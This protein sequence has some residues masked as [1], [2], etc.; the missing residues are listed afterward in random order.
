MHKPLFF[1]RRASDRKEA[2]LP[3]MCT[4]QA[5]FLLIL[6]GELLALALTLAVSPSLQ[7]NWTRLGT[8]SFLIQ[9]VVLLS[10]ALLCPLRFWLMNIPAWVAGL[11]C[12]FLVMVV[13]LICSVLGLAAM[14]IWRWPDWPVVANNLLIAAIFGGVVLRYL[15]VQQQWHNQQQAELTAR[16][17]ALQARIQPH[18]LFNSMNTIASLI[19]IDPIKAE[20]LVEDLASLFRASLA[21]PGLVRLADELELCR[22]Y[23]AIE[24]LRLGDRLRVV[25][26][27]PSAEDLQ[28]RLIPSLLLQPLLEN[29]IVHGISPRPEGGEIRV[30]VGVV[31]EQVQIQVLNP[32]AESGSERRGSHMALDNIR[33]RL[34]VYFGPTAQ[35]YA[36]QQRREDT[37]EFRVEISYPAERLKD[38]FAKS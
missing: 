22:Q 13:T 31:G 21:E 4:L 3:D 17:Q 8:H 36:Q 11:L 14:D 9:W 2:F 26:Q 30:M 20:R 15:Y 34:S 10:A 25:W 32:V 35:F 12:F 1:D 29:A 7:L 28:Q 16:V 37:Y 19:A 33:H 6:L 18:F 38:G 5:V 23:M 27:L 24:Q